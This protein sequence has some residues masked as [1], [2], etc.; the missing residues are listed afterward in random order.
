MSSVHEAKYQ[1]D[2]YWNDITSRKIKH[3]EQAKLGYS[4]VKENY[5]LSIR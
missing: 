1:E 4:N 2:Q 5:L 3:E